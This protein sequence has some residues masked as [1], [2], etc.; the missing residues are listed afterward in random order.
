MLSFKLECL[1]IRFLLSK[2]FEFNGSSSSCWS[3]DRFLRRVMRLFSS[4]SLF[5]NLLSMDLVSSLLSFFSMVSMIEFNK[6]LTISWLFSD[7][8]SSLS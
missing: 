1:T 3:A 7:S 4:S 8:G 5:V 6:S 2:L